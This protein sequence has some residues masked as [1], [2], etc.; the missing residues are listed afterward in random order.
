M[1]FEKAI[2]NS[3]DTKSL[4]T[5]YKYMYGIDFD[6]VKVNLKNPHIPKTKDEL[7]RVT[8]YIAGKL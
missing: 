8:T 1:I 3:G 5:V 4:E 6:D 2:Y 7:I